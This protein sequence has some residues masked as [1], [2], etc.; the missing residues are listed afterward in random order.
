[1]AK[2]PA[3]T[4]L[5][6]ARVGYTVH[7][8]AHDPAAAARVGGFGLEAAAALGAEPDQ[9]FKT[10][11]AVVDTR[12]VV[13]IV[14][15]TARLDLKALAVAVHGKRGELADPA[16]AQRATGYVV[17]GIS[18]LGLKR[19]LPAV[20]DSSAADFEVILVSG[21]RRGLDLGLAPEDLVRLI[22]AVLAPIATG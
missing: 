9:V 8:Y 15:V 14:P 2:T 7:E 20:L 12:L 11:V 18:P 3:M 22:G 21:G 13:G 16:A 6:K 10:L 17:G 1:M 19:R 4:V 5:D